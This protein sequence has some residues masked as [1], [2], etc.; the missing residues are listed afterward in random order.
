MTN[1]MAFIKRHPVWSYFTLT[2]LI[3]WGGILL[4]GTP[5]ILTGTDWQSDPQFQL[6]VLG[7][8]V[9]PPVAGLL[10]TSLVAGKAGL[11][12]LLSRL[13]KWRVSALWYAVALLT[14]PLLEMI[15]L[16]S[17]A[18]ISPIFLPSIVMTEDKATLLL[19]GIAVGLVGGLVEE[20]G[21][22]GFAIPRLR[23]RYGVLTIGLL[24]GILWG[25]W[26]LLQMWWVG[27]T[28]SAQLALTLFLP[29]YFLSATAQLTAY[30]VLMV[31]VYD[32]TESLLVA[33]LM[34]ASYIFSTLFVLAPPTTGLP[35]LTYSWTFAAALWVV[36]VA[37]VV[38]TGGHLSRPSL[39]NKMSVASR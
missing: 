20:L 12:E 5:G 13:L 6:A 3:S 15:V 18:Q 2:F 14:A 8:L 39:H 33:V 11:R 17:L 9:G 37:V 28:S 31:W 26:H 16:L 27:S 19:A 32:H 7:M 25:A 30:R 38:A 10:L 36:V 23:T 29:L 34:H 21:W 4:L 35:F 24:V 22:T 1:I